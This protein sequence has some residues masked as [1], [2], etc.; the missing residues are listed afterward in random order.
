MSGSGESAEPFATAVAVALRELAGVEAVPRGSAG[1]AD[2]PF[3]SATLRLTAASGDGGLTLIFPEATASALARRI[4]AGVVDDPDPAMVRDC[5]GEVA[6]VVAGQAKTLLYGTPDHFT[7]SPPAVAV[8]PAVV[9]A[10]PRW[11][12]AFDSEA[13]GFALYADLPAGSVTDREVS[14]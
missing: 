12:M 8:G 6:N 5:M 4:L 1:V 3:V 2:G 9:P 13:G 10:A 7:F 14:S 11:A